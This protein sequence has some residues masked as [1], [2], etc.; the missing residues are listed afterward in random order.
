MRGIREGKGVIESEGMMEVRQE[1]RKSG[2]ESEL[3]TECIE[4]EGERR[5]EV[6]AVFES[7]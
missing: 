7:R 4:V 3:S 5:G 2:G 1:G 6:R